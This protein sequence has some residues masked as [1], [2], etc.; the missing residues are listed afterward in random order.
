MKI[1]KLIFSSLSLT[2]LSLP[3]VALSAL[4]SNEDNLEDKKQQLNKK[5]NESTE[6]FNYQKNDFQKQLENANSENINQLENQINQAHENGITPFLQNIYK[7]FAPTAGLQGVVPNFN[8]NQHF[9][10]YVNQAKN[11]EDKNKL[12][13]DVTKNL[14]ILKDASTS[15]KQMVDFI[16]KDPKY[17]NSDQ[18]FK[19]RLN[20]TYHDLILASTGTDFASVKALQSELTKLK[21]ETNGEARL[22]QEK[23]KAIKEIKENSNLSNLQ[24]ETF[25]KEIN[26][27]NN[28]SDL[29]KKVQ[30]LSISINYLLEIKFLAET[31][32]GYPDGNLHEYV[33]S[34]SFLA[35]RFTNPKEI[36]ALL[37]QI[38]SRVIPGYVPMANFDTHTK[39]PVPETHDGLINYPNSK[40]TY[41]ENRSFPWL[42]IVVVFVLLL[43]FG[44]IG[45]VFVS[46][47]KNKIKKVNKEEINSEDKKE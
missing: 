29:E 8:Q 33:K 41:E 30:E 42:A 19:D 32:S 18:A 36:L 45:G 3:V 27:I 21:N 16:D 34:V 46:K 44:I 17:L 10:N 22:K 9:K 5:I 35:T 43:L 26:S 40:T 31:F 47:Y 23:E 4:A 38:K 12:G 6:I 14:E 15:I 37:N 7:P 20:K 13:L 24:K 25:E 1:K 28:I 11:D 39:V 2:S